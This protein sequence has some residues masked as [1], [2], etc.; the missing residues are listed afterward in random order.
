MDDVLEDYENAP[1]SQEEKALLALVDR[2]NDETAGG[3]CEGV[4]QA[5]VDRARQAGWSQE[6]IYDALTVCALFNYYNTW[7]DASGVEEMTE[8][9]Y[10]AGARRLATEG[11]SIPD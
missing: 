9:E 5:D 3:A 8:E 6:A 7:V 10:A 2:A 4:R 11:Y 1:I